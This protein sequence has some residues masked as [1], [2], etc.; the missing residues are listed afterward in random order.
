[1]IHNVKIKGSDYPLMITPQALLNLAGKK[2]YTTIAAISRPETI[3]ELMDV[4]KLTISDLGALLYGSLKSASYELGKPLDLTEDEVQDAIKFQPNL[5][6][7]FSNALR[8]LEEENEQAD[9]KIQESLP[10]KK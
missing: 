3:S 4:E 5:F 10:G 9:E 8:T 2:G 1:M 6:E 7:D